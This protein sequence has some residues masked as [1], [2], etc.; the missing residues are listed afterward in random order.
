MI[1]TV[2]EIDVQFWNVCWYVH[3]LT[4]L[5]GMYGTAVREEQLPNMFW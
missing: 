5:N 3:L 4:F 1:V 2:P